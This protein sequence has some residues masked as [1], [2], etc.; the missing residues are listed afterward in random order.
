M[1]F[2]QTKFYKKLSLSQKTQS[3]FTH[4]GSESK[5]QKDSILQN[6]T[7]T[8]WILIKSSY[9]WSFAWV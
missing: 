8:G 7:S 4:W 2:D 1:D 3:Y 5:S 6:F 9:A